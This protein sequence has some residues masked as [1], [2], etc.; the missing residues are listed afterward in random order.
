MSG[1]DRDRKRNQT[2]SFR[3]SPEERRQMEARILVSGMPKG[4]YFIESLLHQ[5]IQITA[6]KYQSDRLAMEIKRLRQ[7]LE[8]DGE[9]AEEAAQDCKALLD[10]LVQVLEVKEEITHGK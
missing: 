5:K 6:G 10:Q 7:Q 4:Q 3:M 8:K 9:E 2:I 1:L